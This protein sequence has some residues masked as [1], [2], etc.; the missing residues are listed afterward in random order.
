[1]GLI[2]IATLGAL[3]YAGYRYYQGQKHDAPAAFDA[4]GPK[5]T[6]SNEVTP[7]RDSGPAAMRDKP[8]TWSKT[9]E[10][11]DESFPAS[12]PATTY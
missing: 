3:G 5:A 4:D 7:V 12:D 11:L 6:P 9:D 8:K 10:G 2:K 1:M